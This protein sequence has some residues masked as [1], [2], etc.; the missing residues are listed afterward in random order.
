MNPIIEVPDPR[1]KQV[2]TPVDG[3]DAELRGLMDDM[4][5]TMYAAPGIGLAA[6]QVGEPKRVIVMDLSGKD[7]DLPL[8][9]YSRVAG[10]AFAFSLNQKPISRYEQRP[11]PS[12]PT[13]VMSKLSPI[14]KTNILNRNK[15]K[16][17]KY[18]DGR[19]S[20]DI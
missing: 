10:K 2:S 5:E 1:L 11:T 6:V 18:F 19:S 12:Q 7:E 9:G 14:T 4:L 15:F 3:V 8:N 13:N 16:Y 17:A 20:W